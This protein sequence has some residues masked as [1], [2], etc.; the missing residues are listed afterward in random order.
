ML[1]ILLALAL[2]LATFPAAAAPIYIRA[3]EKTV[4][5]PADGLAEYTILIGVDQPAATD[6]IF[7]VD[8]R[9]AAKTGNESAATYGS[10]YAVP[11]Q[12]VRIPKGE[13]TTEVQFG[14]FADALEESAETWQVTIRMTGAQYYTTPAWITILDDDARLR[15]TTDRISV[16]A[17]DDF[18]L[19]LE[20]PY[21]SG[22]GASVTLTIYP[23]YIAALQK[24]TTVAFKPASWKTTVRLKSNVP[25]DGVITA[26]VRSPQLAP[27]TVAVRVYGGAIS[28]QPARL[29]LTPGQSTTV[30]MTMSPAPPEWIE[31]PVANQ[32]AGVIQAAN[33][34][35]IA[36]NGNGK[37]HIDALASGTTSLDIVSP[38]G[39]VL[40]T[41]PIEV[42]QP[43]I[44]AISPA[45]GPTRGGT[46]VTITGAEFLSTCTVRFGS[47]GA[48]A[49]FVAANTLTATTPA[50]AAG[51]VDVAVT[52][53]A[54]TFTLPNGYT[55]VDSRKRAVRH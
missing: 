21:P 16:F 51:T 27:A 43:R 18:E 44:T 29:T 11:P 25:D 20:M 33:K 24:G 42:T 1:R 30:T 34:I 39:R 3:Y 54:A 40:A 37:F 12:T 53:G 14:V 32:K 49:T 15:F 47:T 31:L 50:H 9:D 28:I 38:G 19:D 48:A 8:V 26:E 6:L 17:G 45:S 22:T 13:S 55:F 23:L 7:T 35:E 52:C 2:F 36:P 41:L 5:E 46:P 4:L 10:D